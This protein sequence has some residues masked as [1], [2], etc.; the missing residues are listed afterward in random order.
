MPALTVLHGLKQTEV[1][2]VCTVI[3]DTNG[4]ICDLTTTSNDQ[5]DIIDPNTQRAI[6]LLRSKSSTLSGEQF[7]KVLIIG[8]MSVLSEQ[9]A[10]NLRQ[11]YEATVDEEGLIRVQ[12]CNFSTRRVIMADGQK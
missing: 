12:I 5:L 3:A 2:D 10:T 4:G 9:I 6:D 7:D 8:N 1:F 11:F